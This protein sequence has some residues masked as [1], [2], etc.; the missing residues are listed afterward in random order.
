MEIKNSGG[1]S[2]L[3]LAVYNIEKQND[4][5]FIDIKNELIKQSGKKES[6][7]EKTEKIFK[8]L[9]T[10]QDFPEKGINFFDITTLCQ[11]PWALK[12]TT[13]LFA[14]YYK[15]KN[16]TYVA[17][18]EARGF[19]FGPLLAKELNCGCNNKLIK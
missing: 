11:N 8:T 3:E 18:L 19:I 5:S 1:Y 17:G 12:T 7:E 16:I 14:E 13:E 4:T 9:R 2:P 10:V 15:D 6:F